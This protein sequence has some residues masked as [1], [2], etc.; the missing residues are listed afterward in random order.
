MSDGT[1]N[2][3]AKNTIYLYLRM[4]LVMGV[5]LFTS[6]VI[7]QALGVDDFGINNVVG[8]VIGLLGFVSTSMSISVQRHLSYSIGQNDFKKTNSIFS[9]SINLHILIGIII[10]GIFLASGS[11]IIKHF[12]DIPANRIDATITFFY[13]ITIASCFQILQVPFIGMIIAQERMGI[14]AALSIIEAACK[15]GIAYAIFIV[16]S[17]KLIVYGVLLAGVS[18]ITFLFYVAAVKISFKNVRYHFEKNAQMFKE[19]VGFASW[20]ALGEIGWALTIQGVSV[21]MNHFF[22]VLSNAAYGIAHQISIAVNK[23]VSSFQTALNPQIIKHYAQGEIESSLMMTFR[24][25]KFSY[26]LIL[27]I[28]FPCL[29]NMNYILKIWL[30]I[31]PENAVLFSQLII[32]GALLDSL[33][34]LFTTIVKAYGHIRN[35]QIIVAFTLALNFPLSY[36]AYL[37]GAPVESA[38]IIYWVIS[39]VLIWVRLRLVSNMLNLKIFRPYLN[40]VLVP[41]FYYTLLCSVIIIPLDLIISNSLL[42]LLITTLATVCTF[43]IAAY[44]VALSKEERS[45]VSSKMNKIKLRFK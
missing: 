14:L 22:G 30:G 13:F 1:N 37:F 19:L 12:L 3:V 26:I 2:R 21:L 34:C 28:A 32:I 7:L 35:Y 39:I 44:Y 9:M 40:S 17:D 45:F 5:T 29:I 20:S 16:S 4:F 23:F 24:G 31:V 36:I 43:P 38:L 33:S 18:V 10:C 42:K 11:A 25:I 27:I 41:V 6:R 8:G 15:L